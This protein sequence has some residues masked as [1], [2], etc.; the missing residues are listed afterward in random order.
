MPM[1]VRLPGLGAAPRGERAAAFGLM[2][3]VAVGDRDESHAMAERRV[4][5]GHASGPLIAVVRVRAECD[6]IELAVRA[7]R[8]RARRRCLVR[9][10]APRRQ[11]CVRRFG[12]RLGPRI[13]DRDC[14]IVGAAS[15]FIT[16]PFV[17]RVFVGAAL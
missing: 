11:R 10:R 13:C 8:L 17:V 4:F 6:D 2:P 14:R 9:Q 5:R 15:L 1:R 12:V 7:R 3:G 16:P